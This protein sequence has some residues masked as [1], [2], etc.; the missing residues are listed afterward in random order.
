MTMTDPVAFEKSDV[1][2]PLYIRPLDKGW[3]K[4]SVAEGHKLSVDLIC[5]LGGDCLAASQQKIR[6]LRPFSLPFDWFLAEGG[7]VLTTLQSH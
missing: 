6:G 2:T 1:G 7:A 4:W 5:S 3:D